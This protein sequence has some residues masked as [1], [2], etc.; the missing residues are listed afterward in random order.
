MDHGQFDQALEQ[1][2]NNHKLLKKFTYVG[3]GQKYLDVLL[4]TNQF[5]QDRSVYFVTNF[6]IKKPF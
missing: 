6:K 2:Q 3:V 1:T 4:S 5:Q